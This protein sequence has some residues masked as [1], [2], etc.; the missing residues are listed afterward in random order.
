MLLYEVNLKSTY[1]LNTPVY[2]VGIDSNGSSLVT[3]KATLNTIL[4]NYR[5]DSGILEGWNGTFVSTYFPLCSFRCE[6]PTQSPISLLSTMLHIRCL[7]VK[8]VISNLV[9]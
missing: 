1:K 2:T 7:E 8:R 5:N 9:R 3:L 4:A 6:A